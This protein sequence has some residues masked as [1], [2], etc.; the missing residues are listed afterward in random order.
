MIGDERST[1][2]AVPAGAP[3]DYYLNQAAV[4]A[5]AEAQAAAPKA[6]RETSASLNRAAGRRM[7]RSL[8][9]PASVASQ[10]AEIEHLLEAEIGA[11]RAAHETG[12]R[13]LRAR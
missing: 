5:N 13:M 12:R 7:L 1:A 9:S 2:A 8:A 4:V 6:P 11:P 3:A 10:N